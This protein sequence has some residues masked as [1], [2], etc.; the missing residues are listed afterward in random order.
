MF[1]ATATCPE[2]LLTYLFQKLKITNCK[3]IR[4]MTPR[5][6]IS[7]NVHVHADE[8][9]AESALL[10][11]VVTTV[12]HYTPG[13]KAVIFAK[14]HAKVNALAA[15]LNCDPF[16]R[17]LGESLES[18]WKKF[19]SSQGPKLLVCSSIV[20]VG[21]DVPGVR[22]VWHFGMPWNLIDYVQ[23]T[24]RAGRDGRDAFSHL[25]TWNDEINATS[26]NY[27]EDDLRQMVS[28]TD[29]CRRSIMGKVLDGSPTACTLLRRPNLCDN[30]RRK[31]GEPRVQPS[32]APPPPSLPARRTLA[33]QLQQPPQ[34]APLTQ[35]CSSSTVPPPP[36]PQPRPH[37]KSVQ[38][39][40]APPHAPPP[41]PYDEGTTVT[42]PG[43]VRQRPRAQPMPTIHDQRSPRVE[44]PPRS[45]IT[46]NQADRHPENS[47]TRFPPSDPPTAAH[48]MGTGFPA[49]TRRNAKPTG[50]SSVLLPPLNLDSTLT[51]DYLPLSL[52][53]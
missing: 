47:R 20:G 36:P 43:P 52:V 7:Y 16:H 51:S 17:G 53:F 46:Q 12:Q 10:R 29:E 45:G 25:F 11:N 14:S 27:T 4:A 6:E 34:H 23:E 39:R 48:P 9:I 41:P 21:V 33:V 8:E 13:Q 31:V 49:T 40:R 18:T 35:P 50:Q 38:T 30:C 5:P 26:S 22:H 42:T 15:K 37:T 24:G 3:V 2:D 44:Q 28:Q 19:T 1:F 32:T